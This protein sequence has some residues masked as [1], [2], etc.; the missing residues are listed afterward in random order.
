[1]I[2]LADELAKAY[3]R[4]RVLA[5]R[6][7]NA[8]SLQVIGGLEAAALTQ[9][10]LRPALALDFFVGD[11]PTLLL[12]EAPAM[13]ASSAAVFLLGDLGMALDDA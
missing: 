3:T 7:G 10:N 2:Q 5:K 8:E 12:S 1:V 6:V 11:A 13:V 9:G 4:A